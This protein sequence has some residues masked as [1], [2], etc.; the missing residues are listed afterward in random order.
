M[1]FSSLQAKD[2]TFEL[3]AKS[4]EEL[5]ARLT[6]LKT[7]LASLRVAQISGG[8]AAKLAKMCVF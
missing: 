5:L 4:K 7:E 8:A 3:R 1:C 6:E 2:K